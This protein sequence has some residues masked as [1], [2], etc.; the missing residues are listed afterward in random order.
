ME[1]CTVL[2][3][4][5]VVMNIKFGWNSYIFKLVMTTLVHW[6]GIFI[7][8]KKKVL[9]GHDLIPRLLPV[10]V[11][12]YIPLRYTDI[13]M[14]HIRSEHILT[15]IR[16]FLL[17]ILI[18]YQDQDDDVDVRMQQIDA[19]D[20]YIDIDWKMYNIVIFRLGQRRIFLILN[21]I[22]QNFGCTWLH[23]VHWQEITL[24]GNA[25]LVYSLI[26]II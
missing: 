11:G 12:K 5:K 4:V 15:N 22:V 26:L 9:N 20:K 25:G 14:S 17:N 24:L 21:L 13:A 16:I 7:I 2:H 19:I 8:F 10:N 3:H 23:G 1:V 6:L 18:L